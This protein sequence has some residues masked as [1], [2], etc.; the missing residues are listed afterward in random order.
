M[1]SGIS[2]DTSPTRGRSTTVALLI[3]CLSLQAMGG[4]ALSLFLPI[5][6]EDLSLSFTQ[7]G[8]LAAASTLLYALMQIP[9]G[10]LAD[11]FGPKRLFFIG[12]LGTTA[13]VLAFGFI[14]QYWQAL[15]NL[16]A[17]GAFRALQFA[18]GLALLMG[19]FSSERRATA[20]AIYHVGLSGGRM[21]LTIG[22]PLLVAAFDWRFPFIAFGLVGVLVS[23]AYLQLGKEAPRA[24]LQRKVNISDI[25][26]LFRSRLMWLCGY[27]V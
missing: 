27:V 10:Y 7:A 2:R 26:K 15:A 16:T 19:W 12:A 9:A 17:S 13:L 18:P 24:G 22:G 25:F 6:Q 1:N 4:G 23:F 21:L 3:L 14:S 11:R 8:A 20:M 5:I